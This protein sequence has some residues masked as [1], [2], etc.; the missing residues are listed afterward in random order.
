MHLILICEY[1]WYVRKF[2]DLPTETYW[3][4]DESNPKQNEIKQ[5]PMSS[6]YLLQIS[7]FMSYDLKVIPTK[8]VLGQG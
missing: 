2:R 4:D 6:Y 3:F 7:P 1:M 5:T 8:I